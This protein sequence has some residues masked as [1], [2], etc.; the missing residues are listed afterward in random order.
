MVLD[1][2]HHLLQA[3]LEIAAIA[4]A[5]EQRTHVER[6]HGRVRREPPAPRL[7]T[8]LRASPSA[9]AVL[10]TPGSP[11]SSG[12]FFWRRQST[13]MVRCTSGSRPISGSMRPSL[14]LA[15]EVDAISVERALLL[16]G[17]AGAPWRPWPS[18]S[19]SWSSSSTP[20]GALRGIGQ[21]RPLGD[22]VADV[23]DRVVAGH[24]LLLQEVGGVA[25]ALGED[26]DEHVG[27]CHLLAP[28]DC[29]WITA[30]WMTRW[31]PASAWPPRGRLDDEVFQLVVDVVARGLLA[32]K[33]EI[34]R[35]GA[36]DGG[37]LVASS[38]Q[39]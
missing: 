16:L 39:R 38:V 15:V 11:T 35:A 29:T 28:D 24:V 21:A 26:G 8:I 22:A 7:L 2:L 1:L 34:D 18:R 23:I 12:L 9:I 27:A 32:Q 13:W 3:L 10:P 25:L 6:E 19:P 36:H 17:V 33:V 14:R 5:G 31:K 4:R 20:R 30:R 37:R